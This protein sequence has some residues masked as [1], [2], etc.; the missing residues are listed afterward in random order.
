[1]CGA[2]ANKGRRGTEVIRNEP[3]FAYLELLDF[4]PIAAENVEDFINVL[5]NQR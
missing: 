3:F 1:M 2:I 4:Q 5:P